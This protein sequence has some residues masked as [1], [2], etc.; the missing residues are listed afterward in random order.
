LKLF[1]KIKKIMTALYERT[2]M[3]AVA[4]GI[5]IADNAAG[6][7]KERVKVNGIKSDDPRIDYGD[8]EALLRRPASG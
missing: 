4:C 2:A 8:T 3:A 6:A 1:K 5:F 7:R